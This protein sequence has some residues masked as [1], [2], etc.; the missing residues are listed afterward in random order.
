M[1]DL[2]SDEDLAR[3]RSDPA[4]RQQLLADSLDRLLAALNRA[5][6]NA[7]DPDAEQHLREGAALALELSDRLHA[8]A[9]NVAD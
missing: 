1:R 4:F 5:R 2:V 9:D 8:N 7:D 3:A 6:Q